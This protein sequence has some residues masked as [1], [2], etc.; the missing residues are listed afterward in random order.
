MSVS[1]GRPGGRVIAALTAL[2]TMAGLLFGAA[3]SSEDPAA[4]AADLSKF[5]A[6]N[7]VSDNVFFNSGSMG[8][9]QV[10]V[11]L[12]SKV[13]SCSS[14]YVCLKDYTET[15]STRAAD[16]YCAAY[17]GATSER[18]ARIIVKVAKA[19][20]I[21]P[22]VLV[23]MLQKEQGLVTATAP[24]STRYR[25][26]MGYA[27]PDTA[28]CDSRYYGFF[29]QVYSAARQF[30]VYGSG[31]SFTWF[32][33]GRYADVRYHPNTAC[34]SGRV[35]IENQA[36]A[37][38]YYY[39]PYQ[40]NAAALAAGYGTG[41]ACSAYGNRN[42]YNYFTDWFGSTQSSSGSIVQAE[43]RPEV[44]LVAGRAKHHIADYADY[45]V[46]SSRLGRVSTVDAGYV[47]SLTNAPAVTRYVHEPSTGTLYLLQGD[48]TKHRFV[49]ADQVA[50]FGYQFSSFTNLEQF[51]LDAFAT[52]P[53]VGAFMR[54]ETR[55][56]TYKLSGMERRYIPNAVAW[57]YASAG[58]NGF[59]AQM[60]E[61][62][63]RGLTE[64]PALLKPNTLVREASSGDVMLASGDRSIIRIPSFAIAGEFGAGEYRVVPDGV[65]SRH[66]RI[67]GVLTPFVQ[68]GTAVYFPASGS[69]Y[70][71]AGA[72]PAGWTATRLADDSCDAFRKAAASLSGPV[73]VQ[74]RGGG[75]VHLVSDGTL[76]HVRAYADLLALNGDRPLRIL[77][78]DPATITAIGTGAPILAS[79]SFV[80]FTG[81]PEV[82]RVEGGVLRHVQTYETL[83]A[84]GGGRVPPI[85]QLPAAFKPSY[86]IGAPL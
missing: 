66:T 29:N 19:C 21:N 43:G 32:A 39:T 70:P 26:A 30:K 6:G 63:A 13:R 48:G 33:P 27:C 68:C 79:G 17:S 80:Q 57:Q 65:L 8:E 50:Q 11:F 14:G 75:A 72:L 46:L 37:N 22:Q 49:S 76:R 28:A 40:P 69:A 77:S 18:A 81:L 5:R 55:P 51:Q 58:T 84:L 35:Y 59:V 73:F 23:V 24:T 9:P 62:G 74:P 54:I 52:G 45:V 25:I 36:T 2:V 42:F 41:D 82:F 53:A 3:A 1:G 31:S 56:E 60:S 47:D 83:L 61:S 64:G 4:H 78:W 85:E 86:V 12:E 15:T 44:Y 67:A 34:G 20:G 71:Y 7:I 16:A 10:Q 38:L